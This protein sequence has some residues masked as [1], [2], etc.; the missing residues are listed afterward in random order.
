MI[1]DTKKTKL[2]LSLIA[3]SIGCI[4]AIA[5][6][7]LTPIDAGLVATEPNNGYDFNFMDATLDVPNLVNIGETGG[8]SIDDISNCRCSRLNFA[9]NSVVSGSLGVTNPIDRVYFNGLAGQTVTVMGSSIIDFGTVTNNSAAVFNVNANFNN[10]LTLNNA[11]SIS[12]KTGTVSGDITINDTAAIYFREDYFIGSNINFLAA[13]TMQVASDKKITVGGDLTTAGVGIGQGA[14]LTFDLGNT[15]TPGQILLT[16][17]SNIDNT[18]TITIQNV[19]LAFY[20]LGTTTSLLISGNG[21]VVSLPTLI[22]PSNAFFTFTLSEPDVNTLNLVVTRTDPIG[23]NAHISG[24]ADVLSGVTVGN[25]TGELLTLVDEL[26]DITDP[27]VLTQD[28]AEIS[29]LIDGGVTQTVLGA[30]N[31]TFDLFSQRA[32]ELRAGLDKY[33]TGYAAGNRDERGHGSW[34]KLFGSHADQNKQDEVEGYKSETWGIAAGIDKMVTE[35]NLVG[36]GL[37]WATAD[38][39]HDLNNGHTDIN[40]YQGSLYGSW[41]IQNPLFLNWMASFAY[42]QYDSTRHMIVGNFNQSALAEYNGWQYGARGELGYVF[43]ETAYHIIPMISLTYVHVDFDEYREKGSATTNQQVQYSDV[44]AL[45]AAI[46]LKFSY[47]YECRQ[48]LFAPEIHAN[49]AYDLIGDEQKSNAQFVSFGSA[50]E[51]VGASP[52][53]MDYNLGLSLTTYGQSGLGISISYDFDWKHDY[54]A[55]A[56]FVRVRYEW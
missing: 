48:T 10:N 36:V 49:I 35:R 53:R 11:S 28:L 15:A 26:G 6:A 30:Q 18:E 2:K 19:N 13:G 8:V 40:S 25:A 14:H 44:N 55:H 50:Y 42:N 37:S 43:G 33:H 39:H 12:L 51:S 38:V 52:V 45:L 29:P 54:Q 21:G 5:Q 3:F 23:L 56:G 47:E 9:G 34:V 20:D 31:N 7:A 22:A 17:A 27:S 4:P 1:P 16:G 24:V 46:G 41:N 32:A